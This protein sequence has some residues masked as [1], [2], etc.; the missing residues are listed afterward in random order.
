MKTP[1]LPKIP[2]PDPDSRTGRAVLRI[3]HHHDLISA[4]DTSTGILARFLPAPP[5]RRARTALTL[6][7]IA[8]STANLL[9]HRFHDRNL[10]EACI[11][12]MPTDG[13]EQAA[14]HAR[15]LAVFHALFDSRKG[16]IAYTAA[17]AAPLLIPGRQIRRAALTAASLAGLYTGYAEHLHYR[18][19]PWCPQCRW[20]KDGDGARE[21]SPEPSVS[22]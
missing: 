17:M 19:Q 2:V 9:T 12:D 4:I 15:D 20:G 10:C 8:A 16:Q 7:R 14:A 6:G 21:P 11:S 3:G 18:L 22:A 1:D 13:Q 5:S